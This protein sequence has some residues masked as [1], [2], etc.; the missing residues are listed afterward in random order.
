MPRTT[1][2]FSRP[3]T[4][5]IPAAVFA[6]ASVY[7]FVDAQLARSRLDDILAND[8]MHYFDEAETERRRWRGHT[9]VAWAGTG[10]ALGFTATAIVMAT[11]RPAP[12]TVHVTPSIG[13]GRAS[14]QLEA[15][16]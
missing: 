15:K 14:L 12:A 4:Y 13:A 9:I 2:L 3:L 16:F 7:F 11:R 10:L 8:A 1:P 5:A 6:G